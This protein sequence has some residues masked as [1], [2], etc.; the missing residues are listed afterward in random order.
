MLFV[1]FSI[2][3]EDSFWKQHPYMWFEIIYEH[4]DVNNKKWKKK[5]LDHALKQ[6]QLDYWWI[7]YNCMIEGVLAI[8]CHSHYTIPI[9]QGVIYD[10]LYVST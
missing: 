2:H 8:L 5:S 7:K 3:Y 6:Q 4:I 1:S 10:C 9:I